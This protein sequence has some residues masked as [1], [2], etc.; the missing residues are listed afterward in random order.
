MYNHDIYALRIEILLFT[1]DSMFAFLS[2]N[3]ERNSSD[4]KD[5]E[6][7]KNTRK[8]ISNLCMFLSPAFSR[9]CCVSSILMINISIP[10]QQFLEIRTALLIY[11]PGFSL[12]G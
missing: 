8:P 11:R 4:K 7:N 6:D 9:L 3:D 10:V 2:P 12:H 5:K 1:S